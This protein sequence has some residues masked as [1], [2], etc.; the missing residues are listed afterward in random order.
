MATNIALCVVATTTALAQDTHWS[1]APANR[2]GIPMP[3]GGQTDSVIDAFVA[4]RLA[5]EDLAMS[6]AADRRTLIRRLSLDLTGLPPTPAEVAAFV[7][8]E[9]PAAYELLVAE[10]LSRPQFGERMALRWLDLARYADTNGYS[11][12]GGRHMWAWRDWVIAAYNDNM[13][14]DQ[15]TIE[16]IAG[17]LLPGATES[18]RIASGFNRNHMNTHEGGTI[19]EECRVAYV[20]DRVKTTAVTWLGLTVGCAQCHDHKY[21]PISQ[22]DYYRFFAYFNTITDKGNDGNAGVNSVP[23]VPVFDDGQKASLQRLRGEIIALES[24]LLAPDEELLAAQRAWQQ[25]Q[26]GIDHTEPVL[27]PWHVMGPNSAATANEAFAK[28]FGPE[29]SLNLDGKDP[30][31]KPLW[32]L[33]E[34]LVDGKPHALPAQR[35]AYYLHRTITTAHATSIDLSLGS[36]DAIRVW[37]NGALV[38]DKN[39]RRGVKAGQELI[40]LP[41]QVGENQLLVKIINDGGPGGV[42]FKVLRSGLPAE[43]ITALERNEADRTETDHN[44]LLRYFR[45][46]VAKLEPV[47]GSIATANAGI[48]AINAKPRTTAM[49]MA[50]QAMPRDTFVLVRGRYDVRGD[51]VTAG[52]PEFLPPLPEGA[53][54]NRLGLAQWLVDPKHP[55]TARVAVNGL[56]QMLFGTGLVKTS[57]DFGTQGGRPS[58]PELL[59][60]LATEFVQSGWDQKALLRRMVRSATYRQASHA[61]PELLAKD[62]DN[63]LLARGP[64]FRLAAELI[65]DQ[66]LA[67]SGLLNGKLGGPSV[68]PYQ[69]DGLWREMSHFGSTPATEQVYVQDSGDKLYRRSLYTIWKRT[70]PPPTMLAFDAPSR[71]LCTPRRGRTNTPLQ[72]LVLLNET[73]FVEAARQM[74]QRILK[75]GGGYLAT[76]INFGFELT[77][78][79]KPTTEERDVLMATFTREYMRFTLDREAADKLLAI[80]ESPRDET[81]DAAE[82][83][84]WTMV[85]SVLLNLSETVTK[86]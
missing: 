61:S 49:V 80:G 29:A 41:L 22:R 74:A 46:T 36:D 25:A 28:D 72:A 27:G 79:R 68:R 83:A 23:F 64:S 47:R 81:L 18:Q 31:G 7:A 57:G 35:S 8:D 66:A 9:R 38:V 76:R 15:F 2:P 11:I 78:C 77:T 62:P 82:H 14:F 26:V 21:D 51:R 44:A 55:L 53:P 24:Q 32:Q 5:R 50:E 43:V 48:A 52:T 40:T 10:L 1:F 54:Q 86:G 65:R 39:V 70:V 75:E 13:P 34:D 84:A 69:P 42:Y 63:R 67:V 45:S 3:A 59:D 73:G 85:A 71:E 12:D 20:A 33:R 4:N 37:H 60:W 30:D 56:W 6:P 16:Q 17:D 58:H 19:L